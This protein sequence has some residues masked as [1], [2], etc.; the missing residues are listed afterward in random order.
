MFLN[1]Q[2]KKRT[3]SEKIIVWNAVHVNLIALYMQYQ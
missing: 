2:E 3:S 1:Y